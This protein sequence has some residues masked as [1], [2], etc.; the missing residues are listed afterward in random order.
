MERSKA[1]G[2]TD[3]NSGDTPVILC[4]S[5]GAEGVEEPARVDRTEE[6]A[7]DLNAEETQHL[8]AR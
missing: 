1:V 6:W 4:M 8:T 7:V 3:G 2:D 5:T